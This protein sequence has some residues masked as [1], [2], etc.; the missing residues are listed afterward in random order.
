MTFVSKKEIE[1]GG[2]RS[3]RGPNSPQ[4]KKNSFG[5]WR[6]IREQRRYG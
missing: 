3:D 5:M 4:L 2:K 1:K 6:Q